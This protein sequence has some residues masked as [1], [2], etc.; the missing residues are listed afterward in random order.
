MGIIQ[1]ATVYLPSCPFRSSRGTNLRNGHYTVC[2]QIWTVYNQP[3]YN[4]WGLHPELSEKQPMEMT[5]IDPGLRNQHCTTLEGGSSERSPRNGRGTAIIEPD[6]VYTRK[7]SQE[8]QVMRNMQSIC[9]VYATLHLWYVYV[10]L[11]GV[12]LFF[13]CTMMCLQWVILC[14]F[15]HCSRSQEMSIRQRG[16]YDGACWCSFNIYGQCQVKQFSLAR[17]KTLISY[18]L[19]HSLQYMPR[20]KTCC[21]RSCLL[22]TY[23]VCACLPTSAELATTIIVSINISVNLV[24]KGPNLSDSLGVQFQ[25]NMDRGIFYLLRAE[26]ALFFISPVS[27]SFSP[28]MLPVAP[29]ASIHWSTENSQSTGRES[30]IRPA[31][32]PH[33]FTLL[34]VP[35]HQ[36]RQMSE[37]P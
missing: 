17:G 4:L 13:F 2:P 19:E 10:L 25:N 27:S 20:Q 8:L 24:W 37:E 18:F 35:L 26:C 22:S 12:L 11:C 32:K 3:P 16:C 1:P 28:S 33:V 31:I 5:I 29:V 14:H 30:E 21:W 9:H 6:L 23:A 36:G 7:T 15:I 34:A